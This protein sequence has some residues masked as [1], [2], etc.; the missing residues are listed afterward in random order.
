M[1]ICVY[2]CIYVYVLCTY[3][4]ICISSDSCSC[5]A[6]IRASTRSNWLVHFLRIVYSHFI[7]VFRSNR[8]LCYVAGVRGLEVRATVALGPR[9]ARKG[10]AKLYPYRGFVFNSGAHGSQLLQLLQDWE[11]HKISAVTSEAYPP[12]QDFRCCP[13]TP[14]R[15]Q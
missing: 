4:C 13:R 3:T 7:I 11:V 6:P 12:S 5:D 15:S 14:Q 2:V 10:R 9:D 1:F 8:R